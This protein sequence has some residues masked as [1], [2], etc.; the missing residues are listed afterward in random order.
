MDIGEPYSMARHEHMVI[1]YI[2]TGPE[3]TTMN[4]KLVKTSFL[5]ICYGTD[6][7]DSV[8]VGDDPPCVPSGN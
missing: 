6:S 2:Y 4:T 3:S 7:T 8:P 1:V 5:D